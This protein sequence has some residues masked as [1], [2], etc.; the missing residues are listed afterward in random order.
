MF[1]FI[2]KVSFTREILLHL[3]LI[4]KAHFAQISFNFAIKISELKLLFVEFETVLL[5]TFSTF[6][7]SKIFSSFEL[8]SKLQK[9]SSK[10]LSFKSKVGSGSGISSS[11]FEIIFSSL[12]S[13]IFGFSIIFSLKTTFGVSSDFSIFTFQTIFKIQTKKVVFSSKLFFVFV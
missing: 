1:G 7:V 10:S 4:V 5:S 9:I 11:K 6:G 12:F 3:K 2:I 8:S 13:S